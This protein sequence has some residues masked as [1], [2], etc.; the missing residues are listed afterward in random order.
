MNVHTTVAWCVRQL[1]C[2]V[3]SWHKRWRWSR[4]SRKPMSSED[5]Y[6]RGVADA[7]RGELHPFYYQHYYH[8]RRGY[9]QARRRMRR[10]FWTTLLPGR[11][12]VLIGGATL[13]IA[14]IVVIG[15]IWRNNEKT[16]AALLAMPATDTV[17]TATARPTRTPLFPTAT[18]EATPEPVVVTLRVNGFA[19]VANTEGRALRGRAAPGLKAPVRVAFAEGERVRIL[20]G[21]VLAD[22]YIWWR[23]EGRAGTGWA[24]QQSLEGVVW[25]IPVE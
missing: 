16:D 20:E 25:L 6:E 4:A 19:Q 17:V 23:V 22:Q 9:D 13:T 8:Y 11:H 10:P 21:P 7:E 3:E 15:G 5:M 24:A 18:P 12:A 1:S 2:M 14:L